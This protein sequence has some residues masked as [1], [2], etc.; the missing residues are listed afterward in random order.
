MEE[1]NEIIRKEILCYHTKLH[2]T[3]NQMGLGLKISKIPRTGLIKEGETYFD[4]LSLKAY[5]KEGIN[6]TSTN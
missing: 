2:Y 5:M 1:E 4:Y 3:Q 6:Y